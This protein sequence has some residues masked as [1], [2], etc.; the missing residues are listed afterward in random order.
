MAVLSDFFTLY[1][2]STK[3][4]KVRCMDVQKKSV[5]G[6]VQVQIGP[7]DRQDLQGPEV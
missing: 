3:L 1:L 5:T 2:D 7:E 6:H 4:R